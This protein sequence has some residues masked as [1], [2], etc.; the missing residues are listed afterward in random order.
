MRRV[1]YKEAKHIS[2]SPTI[3]A[4][5]TYLA[6]NLAQESR[7]TEIYLHTSEINRIIENMT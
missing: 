5:W 3:K 7:F 4:H 2:Y 1:T 6:T